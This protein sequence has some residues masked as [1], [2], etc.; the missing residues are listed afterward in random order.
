MRVAVLL[1]SITLSAPTWASDKEI[2]QLIAQF[3]DDEKAADAMGK[4]IAM[5]PAAV[6]QLSGLAKEKQDIVARGWAIAALGSIGGTS[7]RKTLNA[8]ASDKNPLV[9]TWAH[10]ALIESSTSLDEL[11]KIPA[12]QALDRPMQM[13]AVELSK[14]SSVEQM[15]SLATKNYRLQRAFL[16][17]VLAKGAGPLIKTM[18]SSKDQNVRR[19][20]ASYLAT[21]ANRG[22]KD[23]VFKAT[24]KALKFKPKSKNVP[25]QGGPLFVP[26]L[27]LE[28]DD[29]RALADELMSW[30]VFCDLQNKTNEHNQIH[31]NLRSLSLANAAGYKSPGWSNVDTK[32]WVAEWRRAFGDK[33]TSRLL[34][35]QKAERHYK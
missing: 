25:W 17:P 2:A 11:L 33:H 14:S 3:S 22:E 7:A 6:E 16:S 27:G 20:A 29:A 31:N 35:A 9:S 12:G 23:G 13:K 24:L 34:K 26:Q 21:L 5:G 10:A 1:L 32:T 15:L 28:K 8:V 30:M 18:Y 19:T 4:V